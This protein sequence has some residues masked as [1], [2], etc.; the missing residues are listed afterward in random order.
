MMLFKK[1]NYL[2]LLAL[3]SFFSIETQADTISPGEGAGSSSNENPD[4]ITLIKDYIS[5]FPNEQISIQDLQ[6]KLVY[7]DVVIPGNNGMNIVI[8]RTQESY[9]G[10]IFSLGTTTLKTYR[11]PVGTPGASKYPTTNFDCLGYQ[12]RITYRKGRRLVKPTGYKYSSDIPSNTLVAF[13]D[14]SVLVC[15]GSPNLPTLLFPNGRKHVFSLDGELIE[16]KDRFGN[17]IKYGDIINNIQIITRNDGQTVKVTYAPVSN[18][19][20][21][22]RARGVRK[23]EYNNKVIEY[24]AINGAKVFIDAEGRETVYTY[25]RY[26]GSLNTITT[27]EGLHVDY[28][29]NPYWEDNPTSKLLTDK[30]ISGP[31]IT[32]RKFRYFKSERGIDR[33]ATTVIEYDYNGKIDTDLIKIYKSHKTYYQEKKNKIYSIEGYVGPSLSPFEIDRELY[34][35]THTKIFSED[36]TWDVIKRGSYGC[37]VHANPPYYGYVGSSRAPLCHEVIKRS[38]VTSIRNTDGSYSTYKTNYTHYNKYNQ[39]TGYNEIFGSNKRYMKYGYIHDANNWIINQ[40]TT[41]QVSSNGYNYTT[42]SE[43]E[44]YPSNHASYPLLPKYQK[45]FGLWQKYY[46]R[47]HANGT[48]KQVEYNQLLGHTYGN[49]YDTF[50]NYKRGKPQL[51]TKPARYGYGSINRTQIID[52]NGNVTQI[53]DFQG[54]IINYGYDLKGRL[55]YIDPVDNQFSDT[56]YTWSYSGG[57]AVLKEDKCKLNSYKTACSTSVSLNKTT[58]FNSL[59]QPTLVSDKADGSTTYQNHKYNSFGKLNFTSFKSNSAYETA[60]SNFTFDDLQRPTTQTITNGGS[61]TTTYLSGNRIKVND[62]EG[63]NTT[64][65]YLAYGSPSYQQATKI[66]SPESVTT[67]LNVDI[68]GNITSITQTGYNNSTRVTQTEYRAYDNQKRL[69]QIKRNDVG[70]T[71]FRYNNIGERIWAAQGQHA[72]SNTACKTSASS[73]E[74]INYSYDNLGGQ[75]TVSYGDST[76]T[77]TFTLDNNGNIKRIHSTDFTQNYNYNSQNLLEDETLIIDGKTLTLDYGY[78]TLGHL[79]S[80]KYPN[81]S[82]AVNFVPNGFGLPTQAIKGSE[83]FVRGG[84]YKAKYYPNNMINTFTYGNGIKHKTQLNARQLPSCIQDYKYNL[85]SCGTGTSGSVLN[86]NYSYDNNLNITSIRNPRDGGIFSLT[87]LTYDGLD[88]LK[89]TTGGYGIGSTTI[90]YD[91]LGNIRSYKNT[92]SFDA[93]NLTYSYNSYNRLAG[94]SG[95][96]S[97]GYNF[98]SRGSYDTRGNVT[99]NG[100]RYFHY[101]LANQMT[102]SGSNRYIYDG[103]NRRIKT[104][105]SKG[106]SYS[107]Y[108]QS[109]KLLYRETSSGG[110]NYIHLGDRLVAKEGTGVVSSGDSIMNYK[111]FGDSIEEPKDDVGYTGHKFDTDLGLSYMQARYY[112]PVIGRFYS[113]D[114]IGFRD[115]HSFNRYAYANNNPYRYTDPTGMNSNPVNV[116]IVS[117]VVT[118]TPLATGAASSASLVT[119]ISIQVMS[120]KQVPSKVMSTMLKTN[121]TAQVLTSIPVA[122][123]LLDSVL[124]QTL[125]PTDSDELTD[126][127][128]Q[129]GNYDGRIRV[130]DMEKFQK[131][132]E[133]KSDDSNQSN[134][135]E[136]ST[137]KSK[138]NSSVPVVQMGS[139]ADKYRERK[140]K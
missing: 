11:Y 122:G 126:K 62:F 40:P 50:S 135:S 90:R 30:T 37:E 104:T 58:V 119:S 6:V 53:K 9:G 139:R 19:F 23:I 33:R 114:P 57:T 63:N 106:V 128:L 35:N 133:S 52:N 48:L 45:S 75:R 61:Q 131:R 134:S 4:E 15:E 76:P 56:L 26:T 31:G 42:V 93:S 8:T 54:N 67:D 72:N 69:C 22:K 100:K 136:S 129:D 12:H 5:D 29:M 74:K 111:P 68:F 27:P 17:F 2:W 71:V 78:S 96:G 120:S 79:A 89:T 28:H 95:T 132:M 138:N 47:Y 98:N 51:I 101:N 20:I 25:S 130:K 10:F 36:T 81:E 32:T 108:S 102:R 66:Q 118:K 103:Y 38:K 44:Y 24:K 21:T 55:K 124:D 92:S 123:D 84:Y 16:I 18:S 7:N 137:S 125:N 85:P 13:D 73:Y 46:S 121:P 105:D 107:M 115:I 110:I 94:V 59:M 117:D 64:T 14:S 60:G 3:I 109:G 113:N 82:T 127:E 87:N 83:T 140:S 34:L 39:L 80:I 65:T 97:S 99:G 112:D 86:L 116:T 91:G 1:Y 41:K 77:R 88:R 49:R 70:T 43:I